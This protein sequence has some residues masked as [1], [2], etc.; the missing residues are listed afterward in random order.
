MIRSTFAIP[1]LLA[2][3]SLFGLVS[4]LLGNGLA[5]LLSWITLTTPIAAVAWAMRVQRH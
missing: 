1:L 4:A 2:A 5:D 3:L